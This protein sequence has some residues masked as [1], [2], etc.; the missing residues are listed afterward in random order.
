MKVKATNRIKFYRNKV[1]GLPVVTFRKLKK[2]E[3]A[4]VP[5]AL[6]KTY[7][8]LFIAEAKADEKGVK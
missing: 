3:L 1:L 8:K 6:V 5:E 7:P 2:G 4:D